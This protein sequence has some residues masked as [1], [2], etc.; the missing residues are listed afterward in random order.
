[1]WVATMAV[2]MVF[3][4]VDA[5]EGAKVVLMADLSVTWKVA[6]MEF[7][8]VAPKGVTLAVLLVV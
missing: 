2:M 7:S 8:K 1:M 3:V 5:K 6:W 4:S